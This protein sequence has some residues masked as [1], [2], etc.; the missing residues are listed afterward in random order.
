MN[1]QN[2]QPL[3]LSASPL[4][5]IVHRDPCVANF[6]REAGGIGEDGEVVQAGGR[7][8]LLKPAGRPISLPACPGLRIGRACLE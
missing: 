7:V 8:H 2:R 6:D 1:M 5:S 3:L 4:W